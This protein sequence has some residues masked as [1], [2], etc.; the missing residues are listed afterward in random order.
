MQQTELSVIIVNYNGLK[1]LKDCFESLKE[2]LQG[3]DFEI[4]V[5]DNNSTDESC[6]FIKQHYPEVVLIES[7][8]NLGFG[9]GNNLA[10]A[11]S[12]GK[13]LLLLNNDTIILDNLLPVLQKLKS[14]KTIGAIGIKM[15]DKNRMYLNSVGKFP[16]PANLFRIKSISR[17]D[18][19]FSSGNFSEDVYEADWVGGS[20]IMMPKKVY[21]EINGFDPD[22]FMYVEDVDLCK[23]IADKGYKRLFM[24]NYSYIHFVGYNKSKDHLI[25]N[26]YDLYIEKHFSGPA[27]KLSQLSLGVNKL[28]KKTKKMF[29]I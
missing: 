28:V 4:V 2:K 8:E 22:Y 3:I 14:D 23:K 25:L 9:R 12:N 19:V 16:S 20:F 17:T 26:G 5:A 7:P 13:Y 24:P 29:G 1:Y 21:E 10:V 15:L 18:G 6:N 11:Y 27:K